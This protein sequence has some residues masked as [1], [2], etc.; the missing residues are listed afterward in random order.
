LKNQRND[1]I[2]LG[3]LH[4]FPTILHARASLSFDISPVSF[5]K[6][7]V[8]ALALLLESPLFVEISIADREGYERG[9]VSFKIGIGNG[10]G[11][12]ILDAKE[13]ERVLDRIEN[14]GAFYTLD[15]AFHLH[16]R[17]D[18]GQRHKIHEDHYLTRLVFDPGRVEVLVH[19]L[20]G[21]RR[22][23][24]VELVRLILD[25]LNVVLSR[26][27]FPELNLE[28]INST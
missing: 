19:H 9:S 6:A 25:R 14:R 8:G 16:Y 22:V 24:P 18:D 7:L 17:V 26:Q 5:Q 10:E 12:D 3:E 27:R 21:V 15:L 28:V 20:R 4:G 13:E 2:W 23:E 11:F 1:D